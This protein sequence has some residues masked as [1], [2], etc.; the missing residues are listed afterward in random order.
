MNVGKLETT[1]IKL[2]VLVLLVFVGV[3]KADA[4]GKTWLGGASGSSNDWNT[5]SNWNPAGVPGT[6]DDVIIPNGKSFYP[7]L[8]VAANNTVHT[9]TINSGGT[10]TIGSGGVLTTTQGANSVAVN[11]TLTMSGGTLTVHQDIAGSGSISMSGGTL[12]IGHDFHLAPTIFS[13]TGGTVEWTGEV[14]SA[15]S[16][17]FPG[18]TGAYQF[19][20]VLVDAGVDPGFDNK[21]NSFLITG[22]WINNGLVTLIGKATTVTFNGTNPQIIGG[23]SSNTFKN[24]TITNGSGIA[25]AATATVNG[26]LTLTSGVVATG[27]NR[28]VLPVGGILSGGGSASYINGNFQKAFSTGAGQSFTFPLGDVSNYA[29]VSLASLNVTTAGSLTAK[30]TAGDH[31]SIAG[32][33]I[34]STRGVN[35]YWTLV[36]SPAGIVAGSYNATFNFVSSDLDAGANVSNFIAARYSGGWSNVTIA[37]R[38]ST[39]ITINGLT[40]YGDFSTGELG[41]PATFTSCKI[42]GDGSALLNLTGLSG[43]TYTIQASVDLFS[44]TNIGQS[45]A[46]IN[47]VFQFIDVNAPNFAHRYYRASYP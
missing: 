36:N 20:N 32:S 1:L 29:P 30:S 25:L 4:A 5:A 41:G 47:G 43:R 23:S 3:G 39:S 44:W 19:F 37:A 12:K 2:S 33:G 26:T 13:A 42:Q 46:N 22:N 45:T 31:P 16:G 34:S 18:G 21:A 24:L 7:I 27:T 11:G 9:I 6:G 35:R 38:T 10:L 17:G 40:A 14:G 8:T 28:M 15:G